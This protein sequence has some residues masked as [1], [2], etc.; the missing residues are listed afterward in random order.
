MKNM[1]GLAEMVTRWETEIKIFATIDE[2]YKLSNL[3]KKHAVD[4]ASPMN[5]KR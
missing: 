2:G 3:Q 4:E 5:S 1:S